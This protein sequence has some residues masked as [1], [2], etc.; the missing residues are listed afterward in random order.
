MRGGQ[1]ILA[2]LGAC[3]TS[4]C[5]LC[6]GYNR[7]I[8]IYIYIYVYIMKMY[9]YRNI[10]VLAYMDLYVHLP[11]EAGQCCYFWLILET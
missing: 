7:Y 10:Y 4:V 11:F 2:C 8:Y 1:C 3:C 5:I 9:M 6:T